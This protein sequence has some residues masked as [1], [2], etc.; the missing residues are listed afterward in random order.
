[1][2]SMD[3]AHLCLKIETFRLA[4]FQAVL[5]GCSGNHTG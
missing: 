3:E 4:D 5:A 1:M 2:D